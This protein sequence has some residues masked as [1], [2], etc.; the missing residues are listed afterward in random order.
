MHATPGRRLATR[1][2]SLGTPGKAPT[3]PTAC[4]RYCRL[5][6]KVKL[7][8]FSMRELPATWCTWSIRQPPGASWWM[9]SIIPHQSSPPAT[10]PHLVSTDGS[11]VSVQCWGWCKC[12][13]CAKG[14][15]FLLAHIWGRC[16]SKLDDSFNRQALY[17]RRG[18]KSKICC[19]RYAE[20]INLKTASLYLLRRLCQPA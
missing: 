14:C 9:H 2:I 17:C 10:I 7:Q 6:S 3:W 19:T 8:T 4:G 15:S 12:T 11:P 16:G 18:Q 5:P 20:D 1:A 13:V